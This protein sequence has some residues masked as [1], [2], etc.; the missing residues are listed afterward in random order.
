MSGC[1]K[2]QGMAGLLLA[3][4]LC[5]TAPVHAAGVRVAV[6][7]ETLTVAPGDT[8]TVQLRVPV[9]G[10]P[11]N[12]YVAVMSFDPAAVRFLSQPQIAQEGP[13]LRDSCAT[14]GTFYS[15]A[16]GGDSMTAAGSMLGNGCATVGPGTLLNLRFTALG[17]PGVT[18]IRLR[19]AVVYNDG[20]RV[21]PLV[22]S[23]ATIAVGVTLAVPPGPAPRSAPRL[24]AVPNPSRG[25]CWLRPEPGPAGAADITILDM[26]GRVVRQIPLDPAAPA[27]SISWDGRD[28]AG[29][30][31]PPG[32]YAA[33][34]GRASH[35]V[36]QTTLI[37]L[38]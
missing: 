34:L 4:A 18:Y 10:D 13:L 21:K 35:P 31:M 29:R 5:C 38:P 30:M 14:H 22:P 32:V 3:L 37:R 25:A 33:R 27:R 19:S 23:D 12:G 24:R 7:P 2:R 15:F 8:F 26:A 20:N 1:R 36:A 9:A 17:S 28:A 6:S 11:F 16:A